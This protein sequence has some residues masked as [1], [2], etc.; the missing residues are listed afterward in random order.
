MRHVSAKAVN[1]PTT[2]CIVL[3]KPWLYAKPGGPGG[4]V[5]TGSYPIVAM[6][7]LL[8]N[9]IGN[10]SDL[11]NIQGL[12]TAPYNPGITSQVTTIGPGTGLAFL[13]LGTGAFTMSQVEGC[14]ND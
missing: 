3:V 5:P 11:S 4:I 1:P 10:E 13:T 14:L 6:S 9:S 2:Q 7:Y 8:G 12:L